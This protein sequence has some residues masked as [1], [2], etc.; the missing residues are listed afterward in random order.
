MYSQEA[1][2]QGYLNKR[3]KLLRMGSIMEISNI[4]E[5]I[6]KMYL[7]GMSCT[8]IAED[9]NNKA[10][11]LTI[12]A[13]GISDEMGR[14]GKKNGVNYIRSKS[15]S[16]KLAIEKG[17][18]TYVIK[19]NK[20]KRKGIKLK[21]RYAV[22]VRDGLKCKLCGSREQLEVDHIKPISK[23]GDNNMD[24]LQTLC[25]LCNNGKSQFEK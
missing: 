17:R 11:Y 5:L 15:E 20:Y 6:V 4:K 13:K 16:F 18:K 22:M 8:E 23:G 2:R 24:N 14:Q 21:D 25:W 1:L 19:A 9:F 10:K 12:T 3:Q 7:G